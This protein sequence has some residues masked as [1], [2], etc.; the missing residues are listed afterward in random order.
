MDHVAHLRDEADRLLAAAAVDLDA[1]VTSCP[2]WKVRDLVHH[3]AE[4]Y[5]FWRWVHETGAVDAPDAEAYDEPDRPADDSALMRWARQE[6]RAIAAVAAAIDPE[7]PLWNWGP[8]PHVA[9]FLPRRMAQE[10][11]VHRWDVEA[12]VGEPSPLDAAL[13]T[14]GIDEVLRV[15]LPSEGRF[16]GHADP[17]VL[18]CDDTGRAWTVQLGARPVVSDDAEHG[19]AVV[20]APA[21]DLLLT[22]W[23]RVDAVAVEGDRAP[24]DALVDHLDTN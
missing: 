15:F 7:Q 23:E 12:A 16:H 17:F 24:F 4:V 22:L 21:S 18:R 5:Y 19:L 6:A 9:G 13:A 14:D 10:T 1:A 11:A 2:G 8:E 3:V 20:H